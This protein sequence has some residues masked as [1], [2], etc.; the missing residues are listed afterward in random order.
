MIWCSFSYIAEK[1]IDLLNLEC[2]FA[3]VLFTRCS[4]ISI[5]NLA[6]YMQLL[7]IPASLSYS[8]T[9]THQYIFYMNIVPLSLLH[10]NF[11]INAKYCSFHIPRTTQS[12]VQSVYKIIEKKKIFLLVLKTNVLV[13]VYICLAVREY[14]CDGFLLLL[15]NESQIYTIRVIILY[16]EQKKKTCVYNTLRCC[17]RAVY[18]V[19]AFMPIKHLCAVFSTLRLEYFFLFYQEQPAGE[20]KVSLKSLCSVFFF[21]IHFPLVSF[22][23]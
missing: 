4:Y 16:I 1:E 9:Y 6:I 5:E 12:Y 2:A 3:A 10:N 8:S 17:R 22:S 18:R 11:Y 23:P 15:Q 13:Y 20:K 7:N 19:Y 21:C 14:V